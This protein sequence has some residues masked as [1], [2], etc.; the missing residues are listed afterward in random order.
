MSN[1]VLDPTGISPSFGV[2]IALAW[3]ILVC[4]I[5]LESVNLF[6]PYLQWYFI[7]KC[8]SWSDFGLLDP[9]SRSGLVMG[10]LF[11][12]KTFLLLKNP[13]IYVVHLES[14][15]AHSLLNYN[16]RKSFYGVVQLWL[17][18]LTRISVHWKKRAFYAGCLWN[19][20][21]TDDIHS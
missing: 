9:F 14:Y 3:L 2:R 4:P 11:Q 15:S 21:T 10:Q 7:G 12:L 13:N 20:G 6:L 8:L 16:V 17:L 19:L 18:K 1:I 5:S